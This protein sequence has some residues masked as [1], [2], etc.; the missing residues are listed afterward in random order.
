MVNREMRLVGMIGY[1]L[2]FVPLLVNGKSSF[3]RFHSNQSLVL[4]L[5]Y[6]LVSVIGRI[7]PFIGDF[8]IVPLANCGLLLGMGLGMYYAWQG[9]MKRLPLIG[10]F[11]MIRSR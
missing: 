10:N 4:L 6:A 11:D 8:L 5:F 9:D 2:F 1:V 7:M 3:L